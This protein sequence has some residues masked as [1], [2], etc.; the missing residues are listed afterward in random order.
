MLRIQYPRIKSTQDLKTALQNAIR[1]EFSTIPPYLVAWWT[2]SEESNGA[3]A[4]RKVL[5]DIWLDEMYHM[6]AIC[7]LLNAIGEAPIVNQPAMAPRY[8]GALP[9]TI[10]SDGD[11][12]FEVSLRRYSKALVSDTFLVIEGPEKPIEIGTD[13]SPAAAAIDDHYKTIGEFYLA[14]EA[15]ISDEG[16]ALFAHPRA[17]Q[18]NYRQVKPIKDVASAQEALSLIRHQGEG[19]PKSPFAQGTTLAHY[20]RFQ[21]LS[22]EMAVKVDANGKPFFD[23]S[24]P[25]VIDDSTDVIQMVDNP[26]EADLSQD[27]TALQK[28]EDFDH[29]YKDLLDRLHEVVN[30]EPGKLSSAIGLMRSLGDLARETLSHRIAA[31]PHVGQFAGPRFLLPS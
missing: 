31:G 13:A 10:G 19:T 11:K 26:G 7:N 2:L 15:A 4:A 18:L 3:L 22:K 6:L 14:V 28:V 12:S 17:T 16:E 24:D 30:G 27:P 29:G 23:P 9:M 8:P 25:I 20:Y 21:S 1:L 5:R